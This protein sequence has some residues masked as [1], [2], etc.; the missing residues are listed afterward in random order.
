MP[1]YM[2]NTTLGE[3]LQD[4]NK[5]GKERP[6]K[7]KKEN[8][9]SVMGSFGNIGMKNRAERMAKCGEW[10]KFAECGF[11]GFKKL[12]GANF[13]RDR[14]CPMC[15]WRRS[16]KLQGQI[17]KIL[18]KAVE[19]QNMKFMFLTLTVR[20]M[21]AGELKDA[22]TNMLK[23]FNIL[24][25]YKA[26]DDNCI[27][28]VRNLEITY[29]QE[30]DDYHPH[31][32]LLIA[33]KPGYYDGKNYINKMGW[34]NLWQK[35]HRLDYEPS[36]Y[37]KAVKTGEVDKPIWKA[38][39]EVGKYSVKDSDYIFENNQKLQ[40]DVISNLSK[41]LKGR[42][43]ISFGKLFRELHKELN[44]Q[45][46]EAD[47]ADLIGNTEKECICPLCSSALVEQLYRWNYG[48][49]NYIASEGSQ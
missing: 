43:L 21:S 24:M 8:S 25:K 49:K 4:I 31:I 36:V 6:W 15:N 34:V 44:L 47:N 1:I 41:A 5:K 33:M 23:A 45:D 48:Y 10:L 16:L 12:I 40:D 30:R 39:A 28:Y 29:N 7:P 20:N 26:V 2:Y 9:I 13:C 3:I 17:I 46:V 32:H 35:A 22:I 18:H 42:R 19:R 11:D 38:A 27:G 14:M 37:I